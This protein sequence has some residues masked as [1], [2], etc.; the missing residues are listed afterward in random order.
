MIRIVHLIT[1][2]NVGGA[3]MMLYKL[4]SATDRQTFEPHV[5]AMRP[6]G[7]VADKITGL[8]I[9]V[10]S[11]NMSKGLPLGGL[12]KLTT[13]LNQIRPHILQTWMYHADLLG[14][15]TLRFTKA[16]K[17]VWNI[18]QSNLSK[19]YNKT[20]T[21]L[22]VR[23]LAA[24]S[25]TMPDK[26]IACSYVAADLHTEFGYSPERMLVIPNGFDTDVFKPDPTARTAIR[27]ALSIAEDRLV[28]GIVARFDP[29]K[30]IEN[31]LHAAALLQ[32]KRDDVTFV[33][34]GR[35]INNQNSQI[36]AW[37]TQHNV[38][39]NHLKLLGPRTDIPHILNSFD[40]FSLSSAGEGFPNVV[41]EA[42][43]CGV[44]CVVTD[45][46]DAAYIV[47]DTGFTVTPKNPVA[48][49]DAWH[50]VLQLDYEER[51]LLGF[52]ARERIQKHFALSAIAQKYEAVYKGML[53]CAAS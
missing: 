44:P 35:G 48:L 27:Q 17:L 32:Q 18:R 11:L 31:F 1:G 13:L 12:A 43:A 39:T 9:P 15:L 14:A 10:H 34:C 28:V 3:E 8:D 21:R 52:Q 7:P 6:L 30:D 45:A 53:L 5:V 23:L 47:D 22:I 25:G 20:R 42:M 19:E 37:I 38:A 41:G 40:L 24:L 49:S 46:G 4:L 36:Q 16:D 26:I 51:Q 29:Q 50:T 2:L 33:L